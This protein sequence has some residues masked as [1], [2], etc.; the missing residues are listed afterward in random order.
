MSPV[1]ERSPLGSFTSACLSLFVGALA[2]YLA[3]RLIE[4]I[5]WAL[6]VIVSVAG[7]SGVVFV[8]L[9]RRNRSW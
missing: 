8:I 7:I 2:I 9:R 5:A 3:V 6:L 1:R 4:S